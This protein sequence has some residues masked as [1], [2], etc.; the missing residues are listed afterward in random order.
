VTDFELRPGTAEDLPLVYSATAKSL[1]S[2]PYYRD[3][4]ADQWTE[5]VNGLVRRMTV[6]PWQLTVATPTGFPNE[7]AGFVLHRQTEQG[8]PVIGVAYV[9][10]AYRLRGLGRHLLDHATQGRPDFLAVLAQ[11][12]VLGWCRDKAPRPQL[13]PLYL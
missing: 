8:K 9:K 1:R 5:I 12:K 6:T 4:P 10:S 13:S 2:S 11:P 7:V 3:I